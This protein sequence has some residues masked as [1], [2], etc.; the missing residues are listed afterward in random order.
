[1]NRRIEKIYVKEKSLS[2]VFSFKVKNFTL[3]I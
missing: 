2:V 1:M 3:E